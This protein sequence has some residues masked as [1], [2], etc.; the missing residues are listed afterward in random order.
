MWRSS[1]D[2]FRQWA[3]WDNAF[4][5][6]KRR[7]RD[8]KR[9]GFVALAL[10]VTTAAIVSAAV[11]PVRRTIET[12]MTSALGP[13]RAPS[14]GKASIEIR[15]APVP[16]LIGARPPFKQPTFDADA[17]GPV[18]ASTPSTTTNDGFGI[19]LVARVKDAPGSDGRYAHDHP[20][21]A[22]DVHLEVTRQQL[23]QRGD[24]KDN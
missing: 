5:G 18:S 19:S 4:G 23:A 15:Q 16:V 3:R 17:V 1:A 8:M 12:P 2:K 10:A 9:H 13:A 22:P 7:S 20:T 21:G 11:A 6:S 24:R 14:A